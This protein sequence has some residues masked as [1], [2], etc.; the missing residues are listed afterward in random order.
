M[1][2]RLPLK[3]R[4]FTAPAHRRSHTRFPATSLP[5][6]EVIF[7]KT[8][9][10]F[11]IR[12]RCSVLDWP[13]S[14]FTYILSRTLKAVHEEAVTAVC[15][16]DDSRI[17]LT[18]DTTG[19][20]KV[21]SVA[22][23]T[24]PGGDHG[25]CGPLCVI[26]GCHDMGVNGADVSPATAITS[27]YASPAFVCSCSRVCNRR[28]SVLDKRKKRNKQNSYKIRTLSVTLYFYVF[29]C[30]WQVRFGSY[31]KVWHCRVGRLQIK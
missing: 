2:A 25:T 4:L 11:D 1:L 30:T 17:M 9:G 5:G 16:T 15:C 18:G 23:L 7:P 27:E 20:A 22:E 19:V 6:R 14:R 28:S 26:A 13:H 10:H 3:K 29:V 12:L 21:W 8:N 31:A 24:D